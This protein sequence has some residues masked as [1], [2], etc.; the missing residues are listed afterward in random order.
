MPRQSQSHRSPGYG[1]GLLFAFHTGTLTGGFCCPARSFSIGLQLLHLLIVNLLVP[2]L[3]K[4]T[5]LYGGLGAMTTLIFFM[6]FVGRLVVTAPV[7]NSS[8]HRELRKRGDGAR[9]DG[10]TSPARASPG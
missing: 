1:S 9:D 4:A 7:L 2:N 5:A 3:E 8:L 10:T 6:Y